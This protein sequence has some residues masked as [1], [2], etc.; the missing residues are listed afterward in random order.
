M[1]PST[2]IKKDAPPPLFPGQSTSEEIIIFV[3]RH[4]V[5]F[6]SWLCFIGIM[7]AL[8]VLT[9]ALLV[10]ANVTWLFEG[11]RFSF[12]AL[13]FGA[14]L[15][16]V[17]AIFFTIWIEQYLDVAIITTDRLVNIRQIGLFNR[18]VAE[19]G[20]ERVQDVSAHMSGYLQSI[21][22]FGTVVVETA[23]G[24]PDFVIRNVAKPH[25]VANT[26]L[27]I[28]DRT[29]RQQPDKAGEQA[30][31]VAV[32][33]QASLQQVLAEHTPNIAPPADYKPE[34]LQEDL[35]TQAM[36]ARDIVEQV[37]EA[38]PAPAAPVAATPPNRLPP[39]RKGGSAGRVAGELIEGEVI[40][41]DQE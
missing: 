34:Q 18:R 38:E 15:L 29:R 37:D 4:W 6:T 20:M 12:V 5:P 1:T 40:S 16:M 33:E 13:V 23:G 36:E 22:Q 25:L 3:R 8:P 26:I 28:H 30:D 10:L 19:L 27:M 35:I 41:L 24:A 17:N 2:E 7:V 32:I 21:F 39:V 9:G 14:Y 31:S 11:Q